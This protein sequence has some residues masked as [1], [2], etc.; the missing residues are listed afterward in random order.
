MAQVVGMFFG[1]LLI[2]EALAWLVVP[3]VCGVFFPKNDLY[4]VFMITCIS[5]SA[6]AGFCGLLLAQEIM[7]K[8]RS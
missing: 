3:I 4:S 7:R 1:A 2:A 5:V 6:F 8:S